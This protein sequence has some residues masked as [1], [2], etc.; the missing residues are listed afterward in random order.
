MTDWVDQAV[1]S[2]GRS[3][4]IGGLRLDG[5]GCISFSIE[6]ER[7]L[8]IMDLGRSGGDEVLAM[9]RAPLPFPHGPSARAAL[10]LADF[11]RSPGLAPQLALEDDDL[12]AT[13]RIP[14]PS[15]LASTLEEAV[16]ALLGLHERIARAE[17][18]R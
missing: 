3:A 13:L 15:F 5:Q 6:G 2:F 9:L 12:V 14:R 18:A 10:A 11:R 17:V 8:T 4:G 7:L 16:A 1:E